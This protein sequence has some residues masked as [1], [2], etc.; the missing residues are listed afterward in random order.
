MRFPRALGLAAA[1]AMTIPHAAAAQHDLRMAGADSSRAP[2]FR[3]LGD[4]HRAITT[5]S[6]EAQR[7][8]DQGLRLVYAFNHEEA[9]RSFEQAAKLDSNCAICWWGAALTLGSNINLP[10]LPDR[11][12]AAYGFERRALAHLGQASPV[13]QALIRALDHRYTLP[14]PDDPVAQ[15]RLDTDYAD[16]MRTVAHAYPADDDIQV[17]FA[18]SMMDLRPWNFW[19][20]AGKP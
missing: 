2:M 15:S 5:R 9:Q 10:A 3:G 8:F 17:L 14:P 11:A 4:H 7:Y 1:L 6:S 16:A 20:A 13:E 18:E 19:T 12:Q